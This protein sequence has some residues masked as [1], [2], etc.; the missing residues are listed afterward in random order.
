MKNYR[1]N[2]FSKQ[3]KIER[4]DINLYIKTMYEKLKE[5][6]FN[7]G[8]V[9]FGVADMKKYKKEVYQLKKSILEELPFGISVAVRLSKEILNDIDDHPTKLYFYH[10]RQVNYLLDRIA[11]KIASFLQKNG[12]RSLPIPASQTIDW[13][14]QRGHISHKEIARL[15]GLGWIGRNNLLVN[16][17]YGSQIRLVSILTD[18]ELPTGSEVE[19]SCGNCYACM[20]VCPA[21]A[22]KERPEDFDH[23]SCYRKLDE[24]RRKYGVGHHI[25][26]ICV[27]V[28]FPAFPEKRKL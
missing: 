26:G 14:K 6:A 19:F 25:C 13:E 17:K 11:L 23:I 18:M 2:Q 9:L 3:V 4:S 7:E 24:F 1:K 5:I 10:Y 8:A 16:K 21:N 22:I 12:Y 15:A 28:C 20:N 27:K